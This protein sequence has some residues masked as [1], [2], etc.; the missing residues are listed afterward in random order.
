MY[1]IFLSNIILNF[2]ISCCNCFAKMSSVRPGFS[3]MILMTSLH[4]FLQSSDARHA[5]LQCARNLIVDGSIISIKPF[6]CENADR[7]FPL[8]KQPQKCLGYK[9]T[10]DIYRIQNNHQNLWH[11]KQRAESKFIFIHDFKYTLLSTIGIEIKCL[12]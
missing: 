4:S 2:G 12:N 7:I 6:A 10:V 9:T 11:S 3:S 5:C 1:N 8:S